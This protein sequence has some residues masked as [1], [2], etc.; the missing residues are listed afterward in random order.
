MKKPQVGILTWHDPTNCGSTLQAYAL[1]LYLQ[2]QGIDTS[3]IN[4]IPQWCRSDYMQMPVRML[5]FKK[6]NKAFCKEQLASLLLLSTKKY[7]K[8]N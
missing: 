7:S 2:K 4:Y 8:K 1:Y 3:I 5:S 6:K